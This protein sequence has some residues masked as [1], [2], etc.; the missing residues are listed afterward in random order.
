MRTPTLIALS[1][2]LYAVLVA[3]VAGGETWR[4]VERHR[5]W[6]GLGPVLPHDT[7][8]ADCALCHRGGGWQ[9]L[10][11]GF[12]FDHAR[13][14]GVP[15][16]GAHAH[17]SCLRCHNDRGPVA[18]FAARGCAGC[19]EDVHRGQ[20]QQGCA[21]CHD[22]WSWRPRGM[23]EL[24][25][26]TRFPLTGVH[27]STSCRACHPGAEVGVFAPTPIDCV[28]CHREDLAAATNPDHFALGYV[29]RCDRCHVPFVWDRV[30]LG[31]D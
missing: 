31:E 5:W 27:A 7:F 30:E 1:L 24:H 16:D 15:L 8:P 29:D 2:L 11:E 9:E 4:S 6:Q 18:D 10:V 26:Q 12:T 28:D 13:E 19:H 3:C 21:T 22:E 23:H 20:L 17:A 14:T 25:R